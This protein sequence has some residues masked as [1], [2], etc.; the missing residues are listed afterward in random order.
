VV[1]TK[2]TAPG[3]GEDMAQGVIRDSVLDAGCFE[4]CLVGKRNEGAVL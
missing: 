2:P 1:E 4:V 3:A